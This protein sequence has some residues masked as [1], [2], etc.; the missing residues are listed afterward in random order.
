MKQTQLLYL[1]LLFS[2]LSYGQI[3]TER[4]EV[5]VGAEKELI[6]EIGDT[7]TDFYPGS[8]QIKKLKFRGDEFFTIKE[9]KE[10][11]ILYKSTDFPLD[12]LTFKILT[13]YN[14]VGNIILIANY[15]NGIVTGF[16]QKFYENGE[17]METGSYQKMKKIGEWKYYNENGELLKTENYDNGKLLKEK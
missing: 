12:D 15:D 4:V 8:Q 6:P 9:F 3:K 2:T 13:K 7:I 5:I 17:P 14:S 10:N 11:G 16:F 1:L